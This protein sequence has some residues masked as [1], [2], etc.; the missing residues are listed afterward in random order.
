[1]SVIAE[2]T[3]PADAFL[4]SDALSAAPEATVEIQ[5]VVAN[6]PDELMPVFWVAGDVAGF[7]EAVREDDSVTDV[8]RL[9]DLDRG[10]SYRA[11]WT[12]NAESIAYAYLETGAAI[13]E[14]NARDD[15]WRLRM[16]F[17]DD[18]SLGRFDDYCREHGLPFELE[19]LYRPEEPMAGGR[20]GLTPKQ[21]RSLVGALERGY[22]AVPRELTM[23]DLAAELGV[24]QQ[25]LSQRLRRA[26]GTLVENTLVISSPAEAEGGDDGSGREP[27]RA[28]SEPPSVED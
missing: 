14:A 1:M 24:T 13:L 26:H 19:R 10:T 4:L 5:R 18:E 3:V 22:Y 27:E 23:S 28:R 11:T 9:D 25:A 7:D 15:T 12:R 8:T 6:A 20:F 21:R 2:F 17:D 16:R